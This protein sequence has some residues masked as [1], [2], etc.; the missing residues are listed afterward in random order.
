MNKKDAKDII[1][2]YKSGN[3]TEDEKAQVKNWILFG[4]F[5][6]LTL[7]D[8]EINKD[9]QEISSRLPMFLRSGK[10]RLRQY[11]TV[12]AAAII[13]IAG[14]S[15][16]FFK[17]TDPAFPISESLVR[18]DIAPGKNTATLI[19]GNG[20]TIELSEAKT[21]V[22]ID[23]SSLKYNDGTAIPSLRLG[24]D[25]SLSEETSPSPLKSDARA[26]AESKTQTL[27][28]NTPRGGQYQV[29]L[30]DGTRV[31]LNAASSIKFPSSFA[32]LKERLV[33]INGEAYFEVAK[34][35]L[36]PFKVLSSGQEICVLGTHFNVNSYNDESFT[37]TT[38]IEGSVRVKKIKAADGHD[39]VLNPGQQSV[40]SNGDIKVSTADIE[41]DL[42]WKNGLFRFNDEK[43]ESIMRKLSRWYDVD[44]VYENE[45][46]KN[47]PFAGVTTRFAN[48]SKLLRMLELTGEV[49]F[50]MTDRQIR[51]MNAK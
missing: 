28:I 4:R 51:V 32:S 50:K 11:Y 48:V 47:E 13:L 14:I 49:K 12:A 9:L 41:A 23:A 10:T 17:N 3:C 31:W 44:V 21:G 19:L 30:S 36:H 7:T 26:R 42:A 27:I 15:L 20:K 37:K 46:L 6:E 22:V 45:A 25:P 16:Y 33:E 43:L 40:L 24:L 18:Q 35:K 8:E 2:R 29:V 1:E 38:L 34:D 5:K 39:A